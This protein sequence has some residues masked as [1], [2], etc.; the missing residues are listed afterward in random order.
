MWYVAGSH[1][2]QVI[3]KDH[4]IMVQTALNNLLRSIARVGYRIPDLDFHLVL[5]GLRCEK[6]TIIDWS[7]SQSIQHLRNKHWKYITE[8]ICGRIG[9]GLAS[10]LWSF[11]RFIKNISV[12][13]VISLYIW[14]IE[15]WFSLPRSKCCNL[16]VCWSVKISWSWQFEVPRRYFL[17]LGTQQSKGRNVNNGLRIVARNS[18]S[19]LIHL[20]TLSVL[21]L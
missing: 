19:S 17:T 15:H 2:C 1:P 9:R 11:E 20:W 3:P 12:Y 13:L 6:S 7:I 14:C 4:Q 5:H 16:I 21:I 18:G 8:T 10:V